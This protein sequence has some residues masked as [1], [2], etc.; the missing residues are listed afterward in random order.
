V[1]AN[2]GGDSYLPDIV[3]ATQDIQV[4]IVFCNAGYMLTGFFFSRWGHFCQQVNIMMVCCCDAS[5]LTGQ[6]CC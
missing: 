4:Q 3:K 5:R 1:P 6:S 2:L